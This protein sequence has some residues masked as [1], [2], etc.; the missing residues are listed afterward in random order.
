MRKW[1]L[2]VLV[3]ALVAACLAS[4]GALAPTALA[5]NWKLAQLPP[6]PFEEGGSAEPGLSG[7]S[8]PTESLCVA[9]GAFDTLAFSQAPTAGAASWHVVHPTYDEPKQELPG[10]GGIPGILLQ[11]SWVARCRLLRRR[12]PLRRGGVRRLR[13]CFERSDRRRKCLVRR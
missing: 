8:C 3:L 10:K 5:S 12:E 2:R 11:P 4:V 7:V 6:T 1:K 13:L 9:V